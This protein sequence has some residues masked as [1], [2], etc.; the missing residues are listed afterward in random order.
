[1]ARLIDRTT[2]DALV[3]SYRAAPGNVAAAARTANCSR[4]MAR[5]GLRTGWPERF[6]WARPI[7]EVLED[8]RAAA[9]ALL[10]GE[11]TARGLL[12]TAP[13]PTPA[14]TVQASLDAAY[15]LVAEAR[16]LGM[17]QRA[18]TRLLE[19]ARELTEAYKPVVR[20]V[21]QTIAA[22]AAGENITME[23]VFADLLQLAT[24]GST[25]AATMRQAM[26]MYRL[27]LGARADVAP[28]QPVDAEQAFREF[29]ECVRTHT[30]AESRDGEAARE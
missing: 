13:L 19:D 5:R 12:R 23:Q 7:N 27:H 4:G 15:S 17:L 1:M 11:A 2:Y 6:A 22:E 26:E 3:G 21:S 28:P 8:E 30:A 10:T 29:E 24:L 20:A 9:H 25:L 14:T 16:G 18:C